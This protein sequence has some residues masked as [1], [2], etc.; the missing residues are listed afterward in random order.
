MKDRSTDSPPIFAAYGSQICADLRLIL[1]P[2]QHIRCM[3][4]NRD[5]PPEALSSLALLS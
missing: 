1:S 2:P 5:V 3:Y 4:S